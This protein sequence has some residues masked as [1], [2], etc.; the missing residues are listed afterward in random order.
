LDTRPC[1]EIVFG[2]F[3]LDR[4]DR[5][6]LEMVQAYRCF[7]FK[8]VAAQIE[9]TARSENLEA[10]FMQWPMKV[11]FVSLLRNFFHT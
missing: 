2:K 3:L 10:E 11:D 6:A 1:E 8:E 9:R 5:K 4:H 7:L